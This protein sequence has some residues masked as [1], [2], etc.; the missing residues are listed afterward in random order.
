M[1]VE[2][3]TYNSQHFRGV[4]ELWREVFP[5]DPPWNTAE[6]AIPAKLAVQPDLLIVALS[7][8]QI[9][10][11]IMAGYDGHRGWLYALAVTPSQRRNGV[12][13]ALVREAE[14]RL[15]N[16]G[17]GK[18]NFQVRSANSAVV[19]FYKKLGYEVE[20]RISMGRRLAFPE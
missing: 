3:A 20:D 10:G 5:E 4:Q 16:L 17:C 1:A 7:D 11:S 13:T 8:D 9:I 19:E 12:A 6:S 14:R 18:V 15:G 2:I